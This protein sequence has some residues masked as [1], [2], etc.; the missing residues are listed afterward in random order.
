[1][2]FCARSKASVMT[3]CWDNEWKRDAHRKPSCF[4]QIPTAPE[5]MDLA[6]EPYYLVPFTIWHPSRL[7][8]MEVPFSPCPWDGCRAKTSKKGTGSPRWV[9]GFDRHELLWASDNFCSV[10]G[11]FLSSDER[12]IAKLPAFIGSMF[13]YTLSDRTAITNE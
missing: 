12:S 2:L 13:P 11:S 8:P 4:R 1:M 6:P 9:V 3:R 5:Q 7:F 10:H